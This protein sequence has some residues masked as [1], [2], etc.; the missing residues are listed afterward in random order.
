[1]KISHYGEPPVKPNDLILRCY[2]EKQGSVWV[3][4]CIDFCLAAQASTADIAVGKLHAQIKDHIQEA[5]DNPE[6]TSKLLTRKAP[7]RF[8]A[9]FYWILLKEA[10][11]RRLTVKPKKQ[12]N[13]AFCDHMPLK[14][15]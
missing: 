7:L 15:A 2:I 14:P 5:F 3:A 12:S 13:H 9:K 8:I 1:M 4:A 10:V 6:F 11:H